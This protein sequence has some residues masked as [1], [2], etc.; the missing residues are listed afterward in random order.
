MHSIALSSEG[1]PVTIVP[2]G[3][4]TVDRPCAPPEPDPPVGTPTAGSVMSVGFRPA[5][6]GEMRAAVGDGRAGDLIDPV[7]REWISG[8]SLGQLSICITSYYCLYLQLFISLQFTTP[9]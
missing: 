6:A 5:T 2:D 9:S 1:N 7:G 3:R 4:A 8:S